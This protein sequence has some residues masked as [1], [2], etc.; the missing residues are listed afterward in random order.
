MNE[1]NRNLVL[2]LTSGLL[3]L[4]IVLWLI[5][6]GGYA[7]AVLLAIAAGAC[8][9]EYIGI[10]LG[11]LR[12]I[13]WFAVLMSAAMPALTAWFFISGKLSAN[14][15]LGPAAMGAA[16]GL[17]LFAAWM[18]HLIRGPLP[19]A[20]AR[21]AHIVTAFLY[22]AGG[23]SAVMGIRG[24]NNGLWWVVVALVITWGN[25]TSAYFFG[26]SLGKHKLYPEVSPGKTWEGFFGGFVGSIGLLFVMRA[27]FFPVLTA[28]D[29]VVLGTLGG[30][31]GPAGDLCESMLK[32]AYGVKD[33][34][35]IIPGHGGMLD[36]VDALIFN[37]PLVLLYIQFV[38]GPN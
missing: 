18:Y 35:W 25:D 38:R 5:Y 20:P 28:V 11:R 7:L 22:G 32:R 27:F 4:P 6:L 10:T 37:A 14:P 9:A 16:T 30:I 13:G 23:L 3:L 19:E 29:A 1:K 33:S 36:R 34:G 8:T 17:I 21:S 24:F 15:T 2:R 26:R 12:I 31:L